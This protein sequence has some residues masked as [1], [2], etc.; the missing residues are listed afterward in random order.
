L[1]T[2][3]SGRNRVWRR[4]ITDAIRND[5]AWKG[6]EYT[7]QPPS[8]RTALQ[9]TWLVGSN[10]VLRQREAPTLAQADGA[11]DA[12][13]AKNMPLAD[14]NDV[15][16]QIEASYDYDPGTALERIRAPLYAVN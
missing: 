6:G 1:P 3:V 14:A 8:L 12:Y 10:P 9:M 7:V 13:I 5:P 4:L 16:Y 15:L 2:Q 11:I